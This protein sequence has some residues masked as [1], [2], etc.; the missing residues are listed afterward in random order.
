MMDKRSLALMENKLISSAE[1]L[2]DPE[3]LSDVSAS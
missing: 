1:E 3:S 2:V